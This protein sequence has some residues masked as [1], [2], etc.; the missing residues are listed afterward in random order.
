LKIGQI[1]SAWEPSQDKR[2]TE[3]QTVRL[4]ETSTERAGP[5]TVTLAAQLAGKLCHDF[6]SPSGAIVSGL[7]LL[8]DPSAQDMR[9]DAMGLIEASAKKLVAMVHFARVA[10]GAASSAERFDQ[11]ELEQLTRGVFDHIRAELVWKVAIQTLEQPQARALLNLA[12]LG[13]G[14]LPTGGQAV[15]EA[16]MEDDAAIMTVT[17]TGPRARL[18][19]EV[20]TGLRGEPLTDGLMGQWI[21]AFWLS[22]VVRVAGGRLEHETMEDRVVIRAR[23]PV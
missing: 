4:I 10:F 8:K 9:D 20:S 5:D 2:M 23:L 21:Q 11:R 3:P 6:V 19:A 16:E 14:A 18:K 7:D 22:E 17:A 15:V 1:T 12:Q 13:G